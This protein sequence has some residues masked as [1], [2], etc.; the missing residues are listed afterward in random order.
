MKTKASVETES[1]ETIVTR[2][3]TLPNYEDLVADAKETFAKDGLELPESYTVEWFRS[4][5]EKLS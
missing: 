2:A 4:I 3:K 1:V 5:M